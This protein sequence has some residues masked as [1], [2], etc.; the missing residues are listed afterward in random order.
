LTLPCA[1]ALA[2]AMP[3]YD[4][5]PVTLQNAPTGVMSDA[6]LTLRGGSD[7]ES[8]AE[9]LARLLY[10]MRNPPGG[11]RATDYE[12]WALEVPGVAFARCYAGRR[13]IGTVDVIIAGADGLPSEELVAA[14]QAQIDKMRP[15]A[16]PDALVIAPVPVEVDVAAQVRVDP[17]SGLMLPALTARVR[18]E[19]ARH[20]ESLAPGDGVIAARLA[21]IILGVPGIGDVALTA[22]SA[23][24]LP[25]AAY[26]PR[27]GE[28]ELS[29]L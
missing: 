2:G 26:W 23:N 25:S 8:N 12:L 4:D 19:L 6:L 20:F 18:A 17:Y 22:P 10:Y 1:A 5:L 15:V 9:L 21:A 29:T 28:V 24:V 13:G 14:V 11:G 3:D 16:C 27:M 7:V